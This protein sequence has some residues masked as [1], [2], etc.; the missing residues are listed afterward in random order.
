MTE[1]PQAEQRPLNSHIFTERFLAAQGFTE[2]S[3]TE[4]SL[5]VQGAIAPLTLALTAEER[6]RARRR[7]LASDGSVLFLQLPRGTVLQEGDRLRS[8]TGLILTIIAKPEPVLTI[9]AANP[10]ALLQ[11]AYHLGNR[12]VALEITLDY[13]RIEPDPVLRALL[14]QRGL[15]LTE[16]I[17]P[18][19]PESG[20]YAR[21]QHLHAHESS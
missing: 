9:R 8:Q 17:A 4:Q 2:Q 16:E 20:A 10:L 13:L 6:S 14:E 7:C 19:M 5:A 18:F 12:H 3:F 1:H 15:S 11:A 21:A